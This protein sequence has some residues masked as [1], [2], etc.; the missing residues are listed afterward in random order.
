MH[1]MFLAEDYH[2]N[3]VFNFTGRP[4]EDLTAFALGYREA[5]QTLANNMA[6][7]HGYAD[8]D[9]YPILFL[10]RHALELYLKAIVYHGAQ[11]LGLI[12]EERVDTNRLFERHKL[13][14]LLP[15]IRAIFQQMN[16]DFEGSRLENYEDFAAFVRDLDTIDPG[17]YAFRYPVNRQGEQLLPNHFVVNV[18]EFGRRMDMLLRFLEGAAI[19][20]DENWNAEAE[21]RYELQQLTAEWENS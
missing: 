18:V 9:G 8:Y 13:G 10:Y 19:G 6:N 11:L 12:S 14:R 20:I 5:G 7:A 4:L 21:A 3:V 17:S 16:W 15:S 2:G 1:R